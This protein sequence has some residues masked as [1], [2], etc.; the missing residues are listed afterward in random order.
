MAYLKKFKDLSSAVST[1]GC[2]GQNW[3]NKP[4]CPSCPLSA[5]NNG[6]GVSCITYERQYPE[7]VAKA[8]ELEFVPDQE[9]ED[10]A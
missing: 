6:I 4:G 2:R 10:G 7:R 9:T 3:H 8:L 5:R 1:L